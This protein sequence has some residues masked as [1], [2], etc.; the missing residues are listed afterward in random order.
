LQL[1]VR[2]RTQRHV[3]LFDL[4]GFG[5]ACGHVLNSTVMVK[6]TLPQ[7]IGTVN[8]SSVDFSTHCYWTYI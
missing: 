7:L 8:D 2:L 4:L 6:P 3:L 1:G 5:F